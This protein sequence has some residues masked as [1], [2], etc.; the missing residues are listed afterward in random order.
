MTNITT[1]WISF[2]SIKQ[3]NLILKPI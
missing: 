1:S 2:G 3:L